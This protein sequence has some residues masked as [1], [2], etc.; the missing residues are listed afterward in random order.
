MGINTKVE[1]ASASSWNVI[2]K[3][4]VV[5]R[6]GFARASTIIVKESDGKF[7]TRLANG[8]DKTY[9]TKAAA[10]SA[11]KRSLQKVIK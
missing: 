6:S 2:R 10:V 8:Q 11:S 7:R 1:R 9:K 5:G 4:G 3:R